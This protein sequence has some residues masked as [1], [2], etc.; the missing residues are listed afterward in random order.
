MGGAGRIQGN[1]KI[2]VCFERSHASWVKV[3][4][5]ISPRWEVALKK[6]H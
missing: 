2:A 5:M 1:A 6:G 3:G 4:E